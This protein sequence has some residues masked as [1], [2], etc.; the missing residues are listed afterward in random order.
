MEKDFYTGVQYS[1][2]YPAKK[3][4]SEP[5]VLSIEKTNFNEIE[6]LKKIYPREMFSNYSMN[7]LILNQNK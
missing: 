2:E 7:W 5:E 3:L 6:S 4:Q 1:F